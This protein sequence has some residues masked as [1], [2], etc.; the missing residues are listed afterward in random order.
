MTNRDRERN[1]ERRID[2]SVREEEETGYDTRDY[3]RMSGQASSGAYG[4]MGRMGQPYEGI[5]VPDDRRGYGREGMTGSYEREAQ[6]ARERDRDRGDDEGGMGGHMGA[7]D[8]GNDFGRYGGRS[9]LPSD[10]QSGG[11][12][13]GFYS[14]REGGMGGPA[15]YGRSGGYGPRD[16]RAAD[17][18]L[19]GYGGVAGGMDFR[20]EVQRGAQPAGPHTGRGPKGYRRSDERISEDVCERLT[21]HGDID[22]SDIEVSVRDGEVTLSGTVDSR[23]TKRMA[24]D[25]IEDITG[26]M[27]IH[28]QLT[29][30]RERAVGE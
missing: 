14:D 6:M 4:G 1:R 11:Y 18:T 23:R 28:N 26:V 22:A 3:G 15:D 25:T 27:E 13:R 5:G 8:Y 24:E 21:Q 19:G 9:G 10:D 29:V 12:N 30:R 2:R 17:N 20:P 16:T 7:R